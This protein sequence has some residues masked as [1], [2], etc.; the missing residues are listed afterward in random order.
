MPKRIILVGPSAT[1]KNFI[2]ETFRKVGY[3]IDCSYTS[4]PPREGEVDGIDYYFITE[5]E[6]KERI[7]DQLFYEWVKYEDTYYGT[8]RYEWFNSDVFIMETDGINKIYK[9]DRNQCLVIY[10]NTP[11]NIRI[12]RMQDRGW[13][14]TKISSRRLVDAQKFSDFNDFDLEISSTQ[15]SKI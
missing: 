4:R 15:F 11:L 3:K 8:G 14:E 10:V 7:E 5:Q 12:K 6:F 9:K 2:R 13:D 1:G